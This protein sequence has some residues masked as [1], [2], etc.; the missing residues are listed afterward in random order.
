MNGAGTDTCRSS[1]LAMDIDTVTST[2]TDR[3]V[4]I[5]HGNGTCIHWHVQYAIGILAQPP[6]QKLATRTTEFS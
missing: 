2:S 1:D 3:S 6:V 5:L 4:S